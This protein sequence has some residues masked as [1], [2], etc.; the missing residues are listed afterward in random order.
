MVRMLGVLQIQR[1]LLVRV[2]LKM[3]LDV[4]TVW[5]SRNHLMMIH[6]IYRRDDDDFPIEQDP[7][8]EGGPNCESVPL[9]NI[10]REFHIPKVM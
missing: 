6:Q 8:L 5:N 4:D 1:I 3:V 10:R 7:S 2:R 9:G